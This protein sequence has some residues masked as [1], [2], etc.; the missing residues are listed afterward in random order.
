MASSI[1]AKAGSSP[2]ASTRIAV[3]LIAAVAVATRF[4]TFGNP[5][6]NPDDQFYLLV[7]D[8]MWRGE[9]PYIDIWDRKPFGL[10]ALFALIARLGSTSILAMHLIALLF[11]FVTAFVVRRIALMFAGPEGATLAAIAYLLTLPMFAGQT[12]QAP[13][14][15]NLFMALAA[16]AMLA[17]TDGDLPAIRRKAFLAMLAAGIAMSIKQVAVVEGMFFGLAFLW[18]MRRKGASFASLA[19]TGSIM[20]LIALAP[21]LLPMLGYAAAGPGALQAFVHANFVS[22]FQKTSLGAGA[23]QAGLLYFLLFMAPL[24]VFAACGLAFRFRNGASLRDRL[25]LGWLIAAVGGYLIVPQFY[26]Q[27]ALPMTVPLSI[28]AAI[29]LD[30]KTGPL[31]VTALAAFAILAGQIGAWSTNREARHTYDRLYRSVE[32]ARRGGCILVNEGPVWLYHSTGACRLTPY[33]F[34]GHLNLITETGSVG[35]D[36][37]AETRRILALRPAVI[38]FQPSTSRRHNPV[39]ERMVRDALRD[40]YQLVATVGSDTIPALA[41][42]QVWQRRDLGSPPAVVPDLLKP[43]DGR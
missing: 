43:A 19:A 37:V 22:I 9:W 26:D 20:I 13:V 23:Q 7:G 30:R 2:L 41:T 27:Y 16:L 33:L 1:E 40:D 14:F 15:F 35:I 28:A 42:L 10:F 25:L 17:S 5:V 24:L 36:T 34:P 8:A 6:A 31:L 38:T 18:L 4:V 39:T 12:A 21:T 32:Q 3:L 11:A 29:F